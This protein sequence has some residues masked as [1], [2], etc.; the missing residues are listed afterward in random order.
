MRNLT[1]SPKPFSNQEIAAFC[2]QF[3]LVLKSGISSAEGI[4]VMLEDAR[5][6]EEKQILTGMQ[7][8]HDE[9][10][11]LTE[12]FRITGLFPSY[13]LHMVEI[14]EE[15]G[16]LDTVMESLSVHYEKEAAIRQNIKSS[17]TYPLF[18]AGMII[19]IILVLLIKVMPIFN[20]VFTQLGTEMTGFSRTLMN[21]G[22]LLHTNAL[23][24]AII[25][26]ALAVLLFLG[27]R[28]RNG[29]AFLSRIGH[30]LPFTRKLYEKVAACRFAD[31]LSLT[32]SSGLVPERSLE[33]A[34]ELNEDPFFTKKL[35][36]CRKLMDQGKN[37]ASALHEAHIFTGTY[38]RMI[39]LGS[40]T[41]NLEQVMRKISDMYQDEIDTQLSNRL[42]VLEP[43]L[44]IVLS[45]IVGVILLSVILPLMGI[46]SS[47]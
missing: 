4:S 43:T 3:S 23:V 12:A 34:Y 39:T 37:L 27:L 18:M 1:Q 40:R 10:G 33:L 8:K 24:F 29:L 41:G 31:V 35:D 22:N 5:T 16:T 19:I 42:S 21:L 47:I 14:G 32:L 15:S 11:S 36:E 28:T 6:D 20:Q 38:A 7:E 46:L 2:G 26:M 45:L 25:L 30:L 17:V 44:V 9:T 13:L